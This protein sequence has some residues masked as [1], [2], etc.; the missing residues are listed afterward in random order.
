MGSDLSMNAIKQFMTKVWSFIALSELYYNKTGYFIVRFRSEADRD[1]VMEQGP[2]S[3]YGI[4]LFIR[5][6]SP[7]F[8]VNEDL[9]R[10]L[11]LWIKLPQLPLHLRGERSLAEIASD[12]GKPVV[13]DECTAK[14]LRI[15]YARILIEIDVTQKLKEQI[16]IKDHGEEI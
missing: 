6:W 13:T 12:I 10:V 3:I 5:D 11:P 2:Y 7:D 4:P 8:E 16:C 1:Q 9:M 14:K 15:T